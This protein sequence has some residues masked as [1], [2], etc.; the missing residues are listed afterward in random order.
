MGTARPPPSTL[1]NQGLPPILSLTHCRNTAGA[2]ATRQRRR[3][4]HAG[5]R[6]RF[7][8]ESA[9]G[10]MQHGE[11]L[12]VQDKRTGHASAVSEISERPEGLSRPAGDGAITDLNRPL[13][14]EPCTPAEL[15]RS[16]APTSG[17]NREELSNRSFR[18]CTVQAADQTARRPAAT[19]RARTNI[20]TSIGSSARDAGLIPILRS[21][22]RLARQSTSH[23]ATSAVR[24]S[25][26]HFAP[27]GVALGAASRCCRQRAGRGR[28]RHR[29]PLSGGLHRP[30][31][32]R[33]I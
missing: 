14:Q 17:E 9:F 6:N 13:D 12:P 16:G 32:R 22:S 2:N 24:R 1:D 31:P 27:G 28:R 4:P 5:K 8:R 3:C 23:Q 26:V 21:I 19:I 10:I 15:H 29:R 20:W 11:G 30:L 18:Q 33:G 7:I 25:A